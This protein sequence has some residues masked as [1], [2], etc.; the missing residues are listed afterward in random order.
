MTSLHRLLEQRLLLD[1]SSAPC[2]N[3]ISMSHR[4][5][6]YQ[7][8]WR[9]RWRAATRRR[10]LWA[11][12]WPHPNVRPSPNEAALLAWARDTVADDGIWQQMLVHNPAQLYGFDTTTTAT[13]E[14]R[15]IRAAQRPACAMSQPKDATCCTLHQQISGPFS[16]P[17]ALRTGLDP[18]RRA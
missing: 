14:A 7:R 17:E 10:C 1:H 5:H 13:A 18:W 9:R 2:E 12:N 3:S 6:R 8:R 4:I 15:R 16:A 11:S